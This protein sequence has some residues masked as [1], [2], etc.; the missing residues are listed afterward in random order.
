[1]LYNNGDLFNQNQGGPANMFSSANIDELIKAISAGQESGTVLNNTLTNGAALKYESL[2]ATLKNLTF[3]NSH[4]QF[5]NAIKKKAAR[6]TNEEYNQLVTYGRSGKYSV[7]EGELPE[8]VDSQYRRKAEFIKYKGIVGQVTDVILQT[9]N[10]ID[11]MAQEVTNKMT[12]LLQSIEN[13][14]HFGDLTVDPLQFDGVYRLHKKSNSTD[15]ATY[16]N[17]DFTLDLKGSVLLDSHTNELVSNIVNQGYG[18]VTDIFAPPTVFTD[19][20]DQKYEQRRIVDPGQVAAG[21][22][23][24]KVTQFVTQFGS[25]APRPVIFG[26]RS[27]ARYVSGATAAAQTAKSPAAPVA[28]SLAATGADTLTQFTTGYTDGDYY[29]AVAAV[30]QYGEGP[31]TDMSGALTAVSITAGTSIDMTFAIT[32][33]AYP[34]TGYVIYRSEMDQ[35]TDMVDTPLYPVFSITTTQLADGYDGASALSVRDRNYDIPNTEKA[36]MYQTQNAD[37]MA[38]KE[39]DKMKKLDL[40][41]TNPTYRFAILYYLTQILYQPFKLGVINNIGKVTA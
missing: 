4:F 31:M 29:V 1:M 40:A 17:S 10:Q 32:D 25:I 18:L 2:E 12:L 23:G 3:N 8:A 22:F 20:V 37:I 33:N 7:L 24:Q 6:S 34:A 5:Y 16:F 41:I 30:N 13:E 19:Y 38:I 27:I 35:T 28:S 39:L 21:V 15:N 11:V 9:N 14:M 36:F 26:R